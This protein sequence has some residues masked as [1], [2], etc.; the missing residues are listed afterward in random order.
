MK[1][2]LEEIE[3][4]GGEAW[5]SSLLKR[6]YCE[7]RTELQQLPGVGAKVSRYVH[8]TEC[9]LWFCSILGSRLCVSDGPG[10]LAGST[11]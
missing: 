2:S 3:R 4:R 7:A 9:Q 6:P 11:S 5:L 1:G 10:S 8:H